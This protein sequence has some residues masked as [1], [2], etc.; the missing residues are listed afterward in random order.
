MSTQQTIKFI[1]FI[2]FLTSACFN[3]YV[4]KPLNNEAAYLAA[5]Q[6]SYNIDAFDEHSPKIETI[7]WEAPPPSYTS[8]P[9]VIP[10][11]ESLSSWPE[12]KQQEQQQDHQQQHQNLVV[13]KQQEHNNVP[14]LDCKDMEQIKIIR[15]IG[16][17]KMK[18]VYKVI[19]PLGLAVLA[20]RCISIKYVRKGILEAEARHIVNLQK[21]HGRENTI[22]YYGEC[23]A[24]RPPHFQDNKKKVRKAPSREEKVKLEEESDIYIKENAA[25]FR[26][27]FTWFS[28][29]G[30]PLITEWY[31]FTEDDSFREC[32]ASHF[33]DADIEDFRTI[34]RQYAVGYE[35]F[36]MILQ[37]IGFPTDNIYPQQYIIADAGIRHADLDTVYPCEECTYEEALLINCS[38]M[39]RLL[40]SD[41]L[42]CSFEFSARN[43]PTDPSKHVNVDKAYL[44]CIPS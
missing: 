42:D 24:K 28:E 1:L 13:H 9:K 10:L 2:C 7:R 34:A 16:E 30:K 41:T 5:T 23:N 36:H 32:F 12:M 15:R 20:K 35:G 21:V 8:L 14:L 43:P 31:K 33:T 37:K 22:H 39:K 17:G 11:S 3:V 25:D 6:D 29:I 19:L 44:Q 4:F 38:V 26:L 40:F 18:K 27:S